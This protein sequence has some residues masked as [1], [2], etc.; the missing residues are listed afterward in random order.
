[1]LSRRI[2]ALAVAF[3]ALAHAANR[4]SAQAIA[5]ALPGVNSITD[6]LFDPMPLAWR[7][8][9]TSLVVYAALLLSLAGAYLGL[10]WTARDF[11]VFRSMGIYLVLCAGQMVWIYE[12]GTKSNWALITLTGPMLVVIAGE[13]MRV[14]NRRWTLFIWPF[15]LVMLI[16]G[17]FKGFHF[18]RSVP[19][20]V[21]DL[22]IFFLIVRGYRSGKGRERQIAVAFGMFLV[23]RWTLSSNF[24]ALTHAPLDVNVGGWQ[25]AIPPAAIVVLGAA[26]LVIFVRDLIEDRRDKQRL[27]AEL[28]AARSV[29]QVLIPDEMPNIPGFALQSVYRP[30]G[31]VGG[32]FFQILP[33]RRGGVLVVIGDV[34][35][36]GMPAAMTVALL[37]GTVRTLAHYT[38][39]PG[40]I[41]AA[42]NQRMLTRSSG[43]FTTCLVLRADADGALTVANAGHIAPYVDG[44]EL[45][46]ENGLPLGLSADTSYVEARFHLSPHQQLTL[47][48]DGVVEARDQSGALFG[49]ERTGALSKQ[50]AEYIAQAAQAFG[51]DDDITALTLCRIA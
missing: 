17:W 51:Q 47:V 49:F 45:A 4:T 31:Q 34:S 48:T 37:V 19:V 7:V 12:G 20:D 3:P 9:N 13:A 42:M 35:G 5:L 11:R 22:L 33:S 29:Q 43:G 26:T 50:P 21:S 41:L 40:E 18:L 25:W 44:Q 39:N 14:P 15:S 1:M 27:A 23:V 32:D 6:T 30:A 8:A 24:R 10:W 16:L 36:K 2:A 38:E 46:L 28:E